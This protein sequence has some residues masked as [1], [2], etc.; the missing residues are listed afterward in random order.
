MS[1]SRRF[2]FFRE[3]PGTY[4]LA[5]LW[6]VVY[7]AMLISQA[8]GWTPQPDPRAFSGMGP[9]SIGVVSEGTGQIFGAW[10]SGQILSGQIWRA[11]T[12]TFVHF[13]L[14]HIVLNVFGLIQLGRLIEEW[15]G[16]KLLLGMLILIGFAGNM[17]A[18]L[19]RPVIG[20]PKDYTL[21]ISSGGGSTIVFGMIGLV[22]VVGKRSRSRMGRYLYNQ[23][24]MLLV[25][26]FLIGLTIPQ[27]DNYAHAGGA[28]A[29]AMIGRLHY[30][31]LA[32]HDHRPRLCSLVAILAFAAMGAGG[33]GQYRM[34]LIEKEILAEKVV[35]VKIALIGGLLPELKDRYVKRAVLGLQGAQVIRPRG[36]FRLPGSNDI[37]LPIPDDII[38]NNR[39]SLHK[40]TNELAARVYD[41]NDPELTEAWKVLSTEARLAVSRPPNRGELVGFLDKYSQFEK[42]VKIS[43]D[44]T[45]ARVDR[46]QTRRVLW[47]MPWPNIVWTDQ[48][49]LIA[50]VVGPGRTA[51]AAPPRSESPDRVRNGPAGLPATKSR[52]MTR[53][54]APPS[55]GGD[56][57]SY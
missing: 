44:I 53:P 6:S 30:L 41:L 21:L 56:E 26:N 39:L 11:V 12:A 15:Y 51:P 50:S 8:K 17:M 43:L 22:A 5:A 42:S 29:G 3:Y 54:E 4:T 14:V 37:L 23:M 55:Q 24:V 28:I 2:E 31:I 9:M 36:H 46:I 16:P 52:V 27:I 35:S 45:N 40:E 7:L 25:V 33:Y 57:V 19:A 38:E 18:A 49:P 10:N 48:G 20:T 1:T 13:S 34:L 32:W 47:K